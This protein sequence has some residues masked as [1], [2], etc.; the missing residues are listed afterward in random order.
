MSTYVH[1]V[2]FS[3]VEIF[4]SSLRQELNFPVDVEKRDTAPYVSV[5]GGTP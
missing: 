3:G 5:T 4:P 2:S 1:T